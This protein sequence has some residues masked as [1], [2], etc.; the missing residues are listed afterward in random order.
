[1]K[2][3]VLLF[4]LLLAVVPVGAQEV[5]KG[6]ANKDKV[7]DAMDIVEVVKALMGVQEN[8]SSENA[9]V[10]SDSNVDVADIVVIVNM[11][12]NGET[13]ADRPRLIVWKADGSKVLY[14]L[15]DMPETTFE[16]GNLVIRTQ[17]ASVEYPLVEILR[18]TYDGLGNSGVSEARGAK[19]ALVKR[20]PNTVT[21]ANLKEGSVVQLFSSDG[22]LLDSKTSNGKDYV[23]ISVAPYPS[24]V[25]LVKYES[26]NLKLIRQ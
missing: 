6:D 24:G 19:K 3:L 11:I 10:N 15:S 2:K 7:I 4:S 21:L 18:Y 22:T 5:K 20:E 23:V 26:Q 1:M 8:Y 16:N 17:N 12:E 14:D 9:D 13:G 25:Y